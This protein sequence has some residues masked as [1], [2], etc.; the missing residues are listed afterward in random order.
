MA[1]H[2]GYAEL[3]PILVAAGAQLEA[4][5]RA[6]HT[7]LQIACVA[8]PPRDDV[9]RAL[10]DAKAQVNVGYAAYGGVPATGYPLVSTSQTTVIHWCVPQ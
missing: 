1:V 10:L 8:D 6:S 3:I 5:N 7:P 4:R 9:V 2:R